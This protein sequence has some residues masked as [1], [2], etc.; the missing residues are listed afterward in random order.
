VIRQPTCK[1]VCPESPI[2]PSI[3][4]LSCAWNFEIYSIPR[5]AWACQ[6]KH[7][8]GSLAS[9]LGENATALKTQ[10]TVTRQKSACGK[11]LDSRVTGN[12]KSF[13]SS[14]GLVPRKRASVD[15]TDQLLP[16]WSVI[17]KLARLVF[18]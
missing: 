10:A 2:P 5:T 11:A 18:Q 3:A 1:S 7:Q 6:L 9:V 14:V 4:S 12:P 8:S 16:R 15:Q 13:G 17:R